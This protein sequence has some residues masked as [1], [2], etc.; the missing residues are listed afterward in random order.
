M[1]LPKQTT[2]ILRSVSSGRIRGAAQ[3]SQLGNL[4]GLGCQLC[5]LFPAGRD[6]D[7]CLRACT[8]VTQVGGGIIDTI[9][10]FL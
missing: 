8:T 3:P 10:P 5:N 1:R 7:D 4:M 9:L 6:R 2:P